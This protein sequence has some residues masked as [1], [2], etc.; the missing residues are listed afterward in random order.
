[1]RALGECGNVVTMLSTLAWKTYLLILILHLWLYF[2]RFICPNYFKIRSQFLLNRIFPE[3]YFGLLFLLFTPLL[4]FNINSQLL[5]ELI[6]TLS[7][8]A[9]DSQS[10]CTA[11]S[12]ELQVAF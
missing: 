10:L 4:N 12:P 6:L 1:V 2:L 3:V 11:S 8:S 9:A 7:F 5:K